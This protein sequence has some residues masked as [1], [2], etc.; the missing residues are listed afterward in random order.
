[1]GASIIAG[2]PGVGKS[3]V[4]E[5]LSKIA[6]FKIVNFGT[7][8]L[9]KSGLK[10]R[11]EIRK[12]E[13][14]KQKELQKMAAVEIKE[15]GKVLV[16]THYAIKT[17]RGYLPG[18][19]PWVM[20]LMDIEHVIVIESNEKDIIHRR[21]RDNTR[22][23]DEEAMEEIGEHQMVNRSIACALAL[24]KGAT[25]TVLKNEENR[26]GECAKMIKEIMEV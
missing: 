19:P 21:N 15:M 23:R 5:E 8:M 4:L 10:D 26:A 9:E 13:L 22:Q 14:E 25:L 20:E 16:D 18:I 17:P 12:L 3:T 24:V 2:I 7:L 1:M 6:N 11:D